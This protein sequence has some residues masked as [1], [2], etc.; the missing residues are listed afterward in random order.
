MTTFIPQPTPAPL[1]QTALPTSRLGRVFVRHPQWAPHII[2]MILLTSMMP[3]WAVAHHLGAIDTAEGSWAF[4]AI[5]TISHPAM[6]FVIGWTVGFATVYHLA[7]P[8]ARAAADY[9][10][11]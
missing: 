1:Q 6:S 8:A 10:G 2:A 7:V 3:A 11:E 4:W 5:A 9:L